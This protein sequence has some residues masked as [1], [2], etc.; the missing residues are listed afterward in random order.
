MRSLII[1][2]MF[3]AI[4]SC[5]SQ[6]PKY[7]FKL[8]KDKISQLNLEHKKIDLNLFNQHIDKLKI[9]GKNDLSISNNS[10]NGSK[11]YFYKSYDAY[12]FD[13]YDN[14]NIKTKE[15]K[16]KFDNSVDIIE[17]IDDYF[18]YYE[19]YYNNGNIKSKLISSWLG[20]GV[21]KS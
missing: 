21:G 13:E 19:S 4:T 10:K 9:S 7:N 17:N 12:C 8:I 14:K 20:F 18:D 16:I 1:V 6:K 2:L 3:I 15:T 5:S 11:N